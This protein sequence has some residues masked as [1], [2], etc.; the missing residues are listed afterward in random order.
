MRCTTPSRVE[1]RIRRLECLEM[2]AR[3]GQFLPCDNHDDL[4][5]PAMISSAPDQRL[6]A[7]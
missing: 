1:R 7:A 6:A 2:Q 3:Y 5:H 4:D